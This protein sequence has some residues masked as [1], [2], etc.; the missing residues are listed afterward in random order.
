MSWRAS[1]W[2]KDRNYSEGVQF[3]NNFNRYEERNEV[4]AQIR[5]T[6]ANGKWYIKVFGKNL[7]Y[8]KGYQAI[9][10]FAGNWGLGNPRDPRT[11]GITLGFNS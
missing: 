6:S 3:E 11:W 4:D 2:W 5:Y 7:T 1:Y 8:D 10:A 9:V